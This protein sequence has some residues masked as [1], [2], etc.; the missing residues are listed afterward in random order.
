M[1]PESA[2]KGVMFSRCETVGT[3]RK[4]R[5]QIGAFIPGIVSD[6]FGNHP[7]LA[8]DRSVKYPSL[9]AGKTRDNHATRSALRASQSAALVL[10]QKR[11]LLDINW[12][13]LSIGLCV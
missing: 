13:N 4:S 12:G 5:V 3:R 1:D 11:D 7:S 10:V 8:K 9:A 6:F 2:V